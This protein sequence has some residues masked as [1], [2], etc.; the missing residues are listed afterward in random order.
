MGNEL[1]FIKTTLLFLI[2][3]IRI[4]IF[5]ILCNYLKTHL[6]DS[7]N[8]AYGVPANPRNEKSFRFLFYIKI[9]AIINIDIYTF[10]HSIK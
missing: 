8:D 3:K 1:L 10:L 6:V 4:L 9:Y 2:K 5:L 7:F